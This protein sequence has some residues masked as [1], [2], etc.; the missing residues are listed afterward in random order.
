MYGKKAT[1]DLPVRLMV[2]FLILSISM[3]VLIGLTEQSKENSAAAEMERE[4][5][6]LHDA[7]SKT[8]YSGI[9]STRTV[10]LTIPD[11]CTVEI[12]GTNGDA[13]SIRGSYDGTVVITRYMERPSVVLICDDVLVSGKHT[14]VITSLLLDG[15]AAAEVKV[16]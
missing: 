13:Y 9:G 7:V 4:L 12:G 16:I 15:K 3:P 2:V 5:G 6:R 1:I 14:L 11:N 10:T 8:H